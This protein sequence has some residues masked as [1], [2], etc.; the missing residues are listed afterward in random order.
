MESGTRTSP[1]PIPCGMPFQATGQG[2]TSR[3]NGAMFQPLTPIMTR[4]AIMP[5]RG[6]I[7][8]VRAAMKKPM[9]MP[10]PRAVPAGRWR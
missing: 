1:E 9:I 8:P 3:L 2:P 10:P 4:P 6:P 7:R 5:M